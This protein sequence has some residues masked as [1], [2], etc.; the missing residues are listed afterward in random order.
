MDRLL[1]DIRFGVRLLRRTPG[2]T[3]A[4]VLAL[5]LGIGATTAIFTRARSGRAAAAAVS[6]PRPPRDG[7]GHQR[8]Q[9]A[10]PRAH[11][12]GDVPR[13]SQPVPCLRGRRR[14]VV[15]AG[16]HHRGGQ[17]SAFG[18]TRSR[19]AATSS[20]C[21]GVQPLLG[22]GFPVATFYSRDRLAVISH[23]LWR[24]RFNGDPADHRQADH[25]QLHRL[26]GERRDAAGVQL[27]Q[28]H[29]RVAAPAVGF[30]AAQPRRA[31]RR[32]AVP[33]ETRGQR[34]AGQRGV[35]RADDEAGRRVQG[36]QRR[37]GRA[38]DSARARGRRL[39]PAG[40]VRAVRRRR[41]S[42]CSSRARTSRACCWRARRRASA[43]WPSARR[44]ARAAAGS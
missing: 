12:A 33:A 21:I 2:F 4:A 3:I 9:G 23:R 43:R 14:L 38:R 26:H 35:A 25:A 27:S 41:R 28:R 22:A 39:L 1:Q 44:S 16:E 24:E 34:R 32:V 15:S 29:G 20:A 40:A 11:L 7:V 19:R 36:D 10:D 18:S 37:L 8:Q 13:L 6:Q 30:R 42:C 5:A 17:G 31:F